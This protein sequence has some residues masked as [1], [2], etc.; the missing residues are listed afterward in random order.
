VLKRRKNADIADGY[1]F[2]IHATRIGK[3]IALNPS[4]GKEVKGPVSAGG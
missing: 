4:A 1:L 3:S 2:L